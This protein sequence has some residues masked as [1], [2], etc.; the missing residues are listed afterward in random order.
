MSPN[1][2]LEPVKPLPHSENFAH[3]HLHTVYSMLDG[4]I[5]I[6]DLMKHVK[7]AGMTSVAITDHGNMY[8]VIDF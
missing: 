2:N 6:P 1:Q 8:G 5:R 4:A 7:N 3:L